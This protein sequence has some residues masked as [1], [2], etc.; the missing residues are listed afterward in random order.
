MSKR[1]KMS[2]P[3]AISLLGPARQTREAIEDFNPMVLYAPRRGQAMMAVL[4]G[5][6][7]LHDLVADLL[8]QMRAK[9]GPA[10]WIALTT[11]VYSRPDDPP[12]EA[13]GL[14]QA[15]ADGDPK[16]IEQ[17]M[18]MLKRRNEPI[19]TAVQT[20]R[21]LPSEGYEWDEAEIITGQQGPVLDVLNFYSI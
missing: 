21:Y 4:E 9:L 18:V 19:E 5:Q 15:F 1:E 13:Q 11:D 7:H 17:I 2:E 8:S 16:V 10:L 6:G 12:L 14:A 3:T 20:Y